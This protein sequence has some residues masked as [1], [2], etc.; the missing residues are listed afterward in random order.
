MP[1]YGSM[2]IEEDKGILWLYFTK[3]TRLLFLKEFWGRSKGLVKIVK[4]L[5]NNDL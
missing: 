4:K 5:E 1:G 3:W 2:D